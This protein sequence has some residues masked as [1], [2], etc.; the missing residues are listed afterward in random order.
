M[1]AAS[2]SGTSWFTGVEKW[3][4][5]VISSCSFCLIPSQGIVNDAI[6]F[7]SPLRIVMMVNNS[8]WESLFPWWTSDTAWKF[9]RKKKLLWKE[10]DDNCL[11]LCSWSCFCLC[12]YA[13]YINLFWTSLF[14]QRI[15]NS[16]IVFYDMFFYSDATFLI[17]LTSFFYI[18]HSANRP[19]ILCI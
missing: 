17:S 15:K 5:V 16:F 6:M 3:I 1:R 12:V 13:R 2:R 18:I 7:A 9:V 4:T 14:E 10:K 11:I 19:Y 8:C